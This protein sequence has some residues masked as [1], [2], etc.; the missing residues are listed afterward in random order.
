M[1]KFA[2]DKIENI[3]GKEEN[4]GYQHFLL[5]PQCI[6]KALSSGSLKVG[7]LWWG[8]NSWN[9]ECKLN[10]EYLMNILIVIVKILNQKGQPTRQVCRS[11]KTLLHVLPYYTS[12]C[13]FFTHHGVFH[14]WLWFKLLFSFLFVMYEP[15]SF[16][17]F[18][19]G[20]EINCWD[21]V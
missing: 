20:M 11:V 16:L 15:N 8:V 21:N 7:I 10:V 2:L 4:A 5:F 17:C 6:Q 9:F 18:K 19:T 1:P 14:S 3:V 12:D 13:N